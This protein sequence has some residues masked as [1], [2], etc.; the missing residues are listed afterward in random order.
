MM[1]FVGYTASIILVVGL[2]IYLR[3]I[4]KGKVTS[5]R[6]TWGVW[7]LVNLLFVSS[8]YTSVGL[9]SS[10]WV[11]LAYVFGTAMIFIFLMRYGKEGYWTWVET[12]SITAVIAISVVWFVTRSPFAVLILTLCIDV[13]GAIPLFVA[14]WK[15]PRAD[16]GPAWYLGFLA[17]FLNLLAI[18]KWDY[19]NA[20]YPLYLTVLTLIVSTLIF[21]GRF[22]GS[23]K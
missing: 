4:L 8:Y 19:V 16:Y 18:E 22:L 17:N 5:N 20:I 10:M 13:L 2:I 14:L 12:T 3:A 9:V 6:V 15:N 11:G 23:N 21:R 7:T 1:S